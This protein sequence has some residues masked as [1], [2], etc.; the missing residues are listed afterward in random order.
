VR[1]GLVVALGL[2]AACGTEP[3]VFDPIVEGGDEGGVEAALP[4]ATGCASDTDCAL[5]TQHCDTGSR[6]CVECVKTS[7][8]VFDGERPI[9]DTNLN[10]CVECN[11]SADCSNG[12]TCELNRC[13]ASCADGGTCRYGYCNRMG[14]C[15]GCNSDGDC[16]SYRITDRC[17]PQLGQCVQCVYNSDCSPRYPICNRTNGRCA[18][19]LSNQNCPSAQACDPVMHY[20]VNPQAPDG[21][22]RPN[23]DASSDGP[24]R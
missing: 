13:F 1:S 14:V 9:C 6:Q 10:L 2:V 24:F 7:Q 11:D 18:E 20:C 15:V 8:C 21:G 17:D 12:Y 16:S 4:P 23:E 5:Q 22:P 19:C 3:I